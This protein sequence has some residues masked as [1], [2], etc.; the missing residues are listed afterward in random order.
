MKPQ[1]AG[2]RREGARDRLLN[3]L[4]T[5][6]KSFLGGSREARP[7][8]AAERP[9]AALDGAQRQ[10]SG[11]LMRVNHSGEVAAQALYRG[12][13]LTARSARVR[14]LMRDAA[15]EELDHLNWCETRLR[16]LDSRISLLNPAWYLGSFLLGAASGLAGDRINLGMVEAT[17]DNVV[18]HLQEHLRR[19]APEDEKTIAIL[20]QMQDDEAQHAR[21]AEAAGAGRFPGPVQWLMRQAAGLMTRTSYWL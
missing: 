6:L 4:D 1:E 5:M 14:R 18:R 3:E 21:A 10:V 8:P 16:E 11:R 19:V 17:E 12:H 2:F 20:Q 13:L 15:E 9:E 7:S